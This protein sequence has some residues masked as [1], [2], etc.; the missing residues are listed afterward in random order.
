MNVKSVLI[1][2]GGT[3]GHISP[4]ISLYSE[5]RDRGIN[6][7]FLTGKRDARFSSLSEINGGDLHYYNPPSM[8][9]NPFKLPLFSINFLS[10]VVRTK[11]LIKKNSV[12]A[13]IGMGGYASAPALMAAR[14]AGVPLFLCEQNT[15]PGRVTRLFEKTARKIYS[16]F[17]ESA[18]YLKFPGKIFHAGNPIRKGIVTAMTKDE[19][20]KLFHLTQSKKVIFAIGGSQGATRINELIFG[21]KQKYS[22]DLKNIGIIW[23]TGGLNYD[24]YREKLQEMKDQGSVYMS[25]FISNVGAAYKA[26][27]LA[28]SRSGAGVMMELAAMGIPSILIPYPFAAMNHQEKNAE[29]FA[30]A[31][32]SVMVSDGDAVPEKIA[33]IIFDLLGNSRVLALMSE[34]SRTISK[35]DAS[36][37][38]ADDIMREIGGPGIV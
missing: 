35:P 11:K 36:V 7:L 16:T 3:G 24:S 33:P 25:P 9:K 26:C 5:F 31:G 20:K 38:I 28:I 10:A 14:F 6:T 30:N 17:A 4:G 18:D 27:D 8:T 29:V 12:S 32:A 2:G 34:K 13:V 22:D 37:V 21:L 19:A 1:I 15:V 23:S